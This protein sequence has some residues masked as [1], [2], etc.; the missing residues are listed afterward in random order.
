M[1]GELSDSARRRIALVNR[2]I[3]RWGINCFFCHEPTTD[4][5]RTI[6]H[7]IPRSRR[8][9]NGVKN[10]R[11]AHRHCNKLAGTSKIEVKH[12]I[13]SRLASTGRNGWGKINSDV[14]RRRL[15]GEERDKEEAS[16]ERAMKSWGLSELE[17]CP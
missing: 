1:G 15:M 12:W 3:E 17:D 8:G 10:L 6:E 9:G 5:D 4:D 2:I 14:K 13:R 11:L 7:L 16:S